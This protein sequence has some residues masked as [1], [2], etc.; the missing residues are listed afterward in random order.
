MQPRVDRIAL[1]LIVVWASLLGPLTARAADWPQWRGPH[2]DG[3][4]EKV[5]PPAHWPKELKRQWVIEVGEGH[6]SPVV[7]GE[8]AFV[9]SREGDDEVVRAVALAGGKEVWSQRYPAPFQMSPY[10]RSHGKGPKSTPVVAGA[11]LYTHGIDSIVSAWDAETGRQLWQHDFSK[12]FTKTS[13][14][15]YGSA[16][17]PMVDENRLIAFIGRL[18]DGALTALACD[19]GKTQWEWTG[20][21]PGYGSAV[22]ATLGGVKQLITQSQ[23]ASIGISASDGSLLWKMP[24]KTEYDQNIV[25]PVVAGDLVIFAGLEHPTT[26]YRLTK[27]GDTW[28]PKPVWE[29]AAA[30]MYMSSPVVIGDR[31]V[32][33]SQKKKG[34]FFCLEL[35]GGK[36]L[37]TSDGRLGDNAAIL[38]WGPT[39][40][41]LT[42]NSDL[43]V[44]HPAGDRFEPIARYRVAD[45]P[46]WAHPAIVS[47]GILIKDASSLALWSWE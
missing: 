38:A 26:A 7:A 24:F 17:S 21:G 40:L 46:T 27:N 42:T 39:A 13:A 23:N 44:F 30:G 47:G 14:I 4:I 3:Q 35:A 15:F 8:R 1:G 11:R 41:A 12:R 34:F 10:A 33:F 16:A 6:A 20:D 28:E 45:K 18:D 37:W 2:R 9:L 29:N 36:P 5:A 19:S 25:T 22:M 32:G 43:I 31:L